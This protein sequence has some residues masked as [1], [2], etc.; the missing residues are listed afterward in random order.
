MIH[1][2]LLGTGPPQRPTTPTRSSSSSYP[3]RDAFK[4]PPA[5]PSPRRRVSSPTK[6]NPLDCLFIP[7]RPIPESPS[8]TPRTRPSQ[9]DEP[10]YSRTQDA[11]EAAVRGTLRLGSETYSSIV[12]QD[13][14]ITPEDFPKLPNATFTGV[15][16]PID[17]SKG[18]VGSS[19]MFP[20]AVKDD[21]FVVPEDFGNAIIMACSVCLMFARDQSFTLITFFSLSGPDV[22]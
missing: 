8:R 3:D 6:R 15:A 13:R 4:T 7:F 14:S 10:F 5:S 21:A 1:I 17:L 18:R 16:E 19:V 22:G 12:E 11:K 20:D 9:T 2:F